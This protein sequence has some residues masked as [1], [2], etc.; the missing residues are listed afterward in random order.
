[1]NVEQTSTLGV[2]TELLAA[3]VSATLRAGLVLAARKTGE[4]SPL[5]A[6]DPRGVTV[7]RYPRAE[8]RERR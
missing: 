3:P 2:P 4:E 7:A 8:L 6:R 1:L 5:E